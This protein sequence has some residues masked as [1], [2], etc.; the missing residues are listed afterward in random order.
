MNTTMISQKFTTDALKKGD[1]RG[2]QHLNRDP[3]PYYTSQR[4]HLSSLSLGDR[5]RSDRQNVS[6][7][8]HQ[9][10]SKQQSL[11]TTSDNS[12]VSSPLDKLELR[13]HHDTSAR[14]TPSTVQAVFSEECTS[15]WSPASPQRTAACKTPHTASARVHVSRSTLDTGHT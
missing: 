12:H 10:N 5:Q 4:H 2:C 1:I 11:V 6:S 15:P 13:R 8:H 3:Q 9:T 14:L 7:R